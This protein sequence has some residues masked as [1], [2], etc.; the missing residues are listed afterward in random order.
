[1]KV[2]LWLFFIL[3]ICIY[4]FYIIY[5]YFY[6]YFYNWNLKKRSSQAQAN[7]YNWGYTP[8]ELWPLTNKCN[9]KDMMK[10][11]WGYHHNTSKSGSQATQFEYPWVWLSFSEESGEESCGKM[12]ACRMEPVRN[13][14]PWQT[15]RVAAHDWCTCTASQG[16]LGLAK[17]CDGY[18]NILWLTSGGH[19]W[20]AHPFYR[21]TNV[22]LV[23]N[24]WF[25]LCRLFLGGFNSR[26]E[27]SSWKK[28]ISSKITRV[29][30]TLEF[31]TNVIWR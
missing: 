27:S 9:K 1:M 3:F 31:M 12:W 17:P 19:Q 26:N 21:M 15:K 10:L 18:T 16:E 8:S 20:C 24:S 13:P 2:F 14:I 6:T 22:S 7:S 5:F 29:K 23:A 4:L 30:G 25:T 11:V 28:T